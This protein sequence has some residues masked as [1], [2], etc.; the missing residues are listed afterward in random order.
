VKQVVTVEL[1]NGDRY[2]GEL[3][4]AED[5][6]SIQMSSVTHTA[7]DG[8]VRIRADLPAWQ[9]RAFVYST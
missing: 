4:G 7:K 2:R 8:R 1:K 5:N 9:Q 3:T 6:M